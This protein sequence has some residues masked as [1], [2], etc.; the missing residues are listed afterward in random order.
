[1]SRSQIFIVTKRN[2]EGE[3]FLATSGFRESIWRR[4]RSE[5]TEFHSKVDA[6]K[7]AKTHGGEIKQES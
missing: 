3:V 6:E 5:A 7:A 4:S 2:S 1:M